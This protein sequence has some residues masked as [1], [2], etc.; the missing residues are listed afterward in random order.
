MKK[1]FLEVDR[2][3]LDLNTVGTISL[4][5]A[6]LPHMIK[7]REG[8]VVIVSSVLGKFGNCYIFLT[9]AHNLLMLVYDFIEYYIWLFLIGLPYEATYCASKHALQVWSVT[10]NQILIGYYCG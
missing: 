4:T 5:K 1:T 9:E 8:E 2:S 6:I 7:R 3:L 10:V